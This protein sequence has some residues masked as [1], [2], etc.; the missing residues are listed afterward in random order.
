MTMEKDANYFAVGIFVSL[1]LMAL[2]GFLIWLAGFHSTGHY[3][4]YTVY[5]TDPVSGLNVDAPVNYKGVEV[6]KI[7]AMRLSADRSDLIKVD[8]EVKDSTP[9]RA[10]TLAKVELSGITGQSSIELATETTDTTPPRQIPGEQYPVLKG[11]GSPLADFFDNLPKIGN[12]VQTTLSAVDAL[13]QG[14]TKMVDS[15]RA[16]AE[17]L[18][19]DPSQI[20]HAP[21]NKGV[22]I[23][24]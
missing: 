2:V 14:S 9:V 1:S 21:S 13:S 3:D 8:I 7:L 12:H 10:E 24:K 5:F 6:G 23:P 11:T 16:L 19:E 15:I 18:K 4:R 17:K 20:L 22:E